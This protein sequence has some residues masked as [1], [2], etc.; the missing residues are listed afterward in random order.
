MC[1][2]TEKRLVHVCELVAGLIETIILSELIM[3]LS[4]SEQIST[5]WCK[6]NCSERVKILDLFDTAWPS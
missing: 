5:L 3:P 6:S 4:S 1:D 2:E